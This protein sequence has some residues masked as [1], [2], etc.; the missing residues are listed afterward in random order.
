MIKYVVIFFL[1]TNLIQSQEQDLNFVIKIDNNLDITL[2]NM[3]LLV[4]NVEYPLTY[5]PG[6]VKI[7][8]EVLSKVENSKPIKLKFTWNEIN[9]DEVNYR[10]V[11]DINKNWIKS[12]Y[13]IL[14]IYNLDK[15]Y[16][17]KVFGKQ[18]QGKHYIYEYTSSE[19]SELLP[20]RKRN[21][22]CNY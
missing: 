21:I 11:L 7:K 2:S 6:V 17:R 20:R 3:T 19:G 9:N 8:Q 16:N 13:F 4:E 22:G 5:Y 15:K 14:S 10:Y 1:M 12:N 18:K